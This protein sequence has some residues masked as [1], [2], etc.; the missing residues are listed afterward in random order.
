MPNINKYRITVIVLAIAVVALAIILITENGGR[1]PSAKSLDQYI[2]SSTEQSATAPGAA[3]GGTTKGATGGAANTSGATKT[4]TVGFTI[5]LR[6]PVAGETWTI[7]QQNTISWDRAAGV[8]GQ[9]ELL[10]ATTKAL[11][12]VIIPQTGPNQTSYTWNTRDILLSRTN[13]LKKN[14]V[15]GTYLIRL[16]FD[17]NEL[18]P[19]TSAP[20]TIAQ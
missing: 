11:V 2:A 6:T 7:S 19:V 9:I 8:T 15:P 10:N 18:A 3:T 12:G 5:H 4:A 1:A 17:G 16:A 13:P 14:V 20:L